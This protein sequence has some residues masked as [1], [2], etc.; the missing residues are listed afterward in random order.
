MSLVTDTIQATSYV[1]LALGATIASAATPNINDATG[2]T[3][4]I[5]G[6]TTITGFSTA[7]QSGVTRKLIFNNAVLLTH[8][9]SLKLFGDA[10]ITTVDGDV[11]I[12]VAET[13]SVWRMVG[14][15]RASGVT[16]GQFDSDAILNGAITSTKIGDAAII[17]SKMRVK[18]VTALTDAN[19]TLTNEQMLGGVLT[20][21]PTA[22][23][24]LTTPTGTNICGL[25]TSYQTGTSF[26]FTIVCL[27]AFNAKLTAGVGVT[28]VGNETA[29]NSSATFLAVVTGTNT[30]TIYR[31]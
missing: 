5:S 24:D 10:N 25:L 11:A 15:Y 1:N 16:G 20:I 2:N 26:E 31:K 7:S 21:T 8:S 4:F 23:R 29:N 30:V 17:P 28:L 19:A 6:T 14:F 12:F 27:A 13:T 9:A 22:N 3:F 18:T